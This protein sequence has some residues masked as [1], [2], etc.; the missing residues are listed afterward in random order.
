MFAAEKAAACF[1]EGWF[2]GLVFVVIADSELA[3]VVAGGTW[4]WFHISFVPHCVVRPL[5]SIAILF[6]DCAKHWY[7][8]CGFQA[9]LRSFAAPCVRSEQTS[10]G[11]FC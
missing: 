1:D 9:D 10:F 6:N 2:S 3:T 8:N 5:E 7:I 11:Q 4:P